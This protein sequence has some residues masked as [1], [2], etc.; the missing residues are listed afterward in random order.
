MG[1]YYISSIDSPLSR[2][3]ISFVGFP[4]LFSRQPNVD[5]TTNW[6]AASDKPDSAPDGSVKSGLWRV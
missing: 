1:R 3:S 2:R 5:V 4:E 6:T